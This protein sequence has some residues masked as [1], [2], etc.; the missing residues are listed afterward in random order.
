MGNSNSE[1]GELAAFSSAMAEVADGFSPLPEPGQNAALDALC[2]RKNLT[3]NDLVRVGARMKD[4]ITL[5]FLYGTGIKYRQLT[6]DKRWAH[7]GS[8]FPHMKIVPSQ[9]GNHDTILIAEGET[10]GAKL[11]SLYDADVA[12]LPAGARRWTDGYA[13]Q[14]QD[15][16]LVLVALDNDEAGREGTAKVRMSVPNAVPFPPPESY[17]D[18]C[19]IEDESLFPPLPTEAPEPD[20]STQLWVPAGTMLE[21]PEPNI[22]SYYENALLPVGGLAIVH[23]WAKSFKSFVCFDMMSMLAQGQ[24]WALFEPTEEPVKVLVVQY[25]IPWPFYRQRVLQMQDRAPERELFDQH[26]YTWT[27]LARPRIKAGDKKAEDFFVRNVVES[28][29]QV[30][31]MD[32]IRRA[33]GDADMNSE[34]DVRRMLSLFERLN[35]EGITVVATHHDNKASVKG[36]GGDPA[37]MTGSGAWVGDP[38]TII[39][40]E[41]PEGEDHRTSLKR[42]MNFT[43]RNAPMIGSRAFT[44]TDHGIEYHN[45]GWETD[46]DPTAPE[47]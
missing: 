12:I 35:A 38:D 42:T 21:L 4:N 33:A 17:N 32:P 41:L 31:L 23:G 2:K 29:C 36:G 27:P 25:E 24:P 16:Q 10:D 11:S 45:E 28:G 43:L 22:T 26:Y 8:E 19:A 13:A 44:M 1:W 18:W 7:F 47:I 5:A 46:E 9:G 34:Q 14:L 20:P 39:S 15:Y 30:V 6:D 40:I 37:A 3:V